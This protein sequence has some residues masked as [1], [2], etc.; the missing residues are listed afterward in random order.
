MKKL[1]VVAVIAVAA[2][3]SCKKDYDCTYD[4]T[5]SDDTTTTYTSSCLK[6][7][8]SVKDDYVSSL[9]AAGYDNVSCD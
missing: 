4:Y 9:E 8:G 5:W 7:S 2:L 1:L 3:S 6:C